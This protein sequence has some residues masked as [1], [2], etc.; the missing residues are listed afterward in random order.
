MGDST[1]EEDHV[2]ASLGWASTRNL[3]ILFVIED[4]NYAILTEKKDRRNWE[5]SEVGK[6]FKIDS[7]NIDDD[8]KNIK[9]T[10]EN[11]IFKKPLLLNINTNRLSWHVGAG[12]NNKETFDRL[13]NEI[14]SIG[15]QAKLIDYNIKK[16]ID[17]LWKKH[18]GQQ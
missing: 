13:K 1:I 9:K 6:G 2:L 3:P 7:Y 17:R 8:P 5:A 16:N 15:K 12:I 11:K 14:N 10:L 18:L 4:N